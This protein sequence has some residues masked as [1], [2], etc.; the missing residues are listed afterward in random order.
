MSGGARPLQ[1]QTM[2]LGTIMIIH[3]ETV[4]TIEVMGMLCCYVVFEVHNNSYT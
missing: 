3:G 1:T 2:F 4:L